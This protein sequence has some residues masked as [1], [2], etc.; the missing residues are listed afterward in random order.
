LAEDDLTALVVVPVIA[1]I[2]IGG[3]LDD[4]GHKVDDGLTFVRDKA[5][6]TK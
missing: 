2:A 6:K 5:Q 4:V 3:V 1:L